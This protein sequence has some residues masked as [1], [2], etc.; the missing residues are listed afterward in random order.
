MSRV[1]AV[2]S[3]D[4]QILKSNPPQLAVSAAGQVSTSGWHSP[5]LAAWRYVTPPED[6]IQ[7]FDF[8][9]VP[10]EGIALTV[11]RPIV[12]EVVAAADP[13]N[14]WGPG[15]PL[16]GVRV[17]AQTNSMVASLISDGPLV[18]L[19]VDMDFPVRWPG[20]GGAAPEQLIGKSLRVYHTGDPITFD[21]RPSRA[22]VELGADERIVKVWVG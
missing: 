16:L 2:T 15:K 17:H 21:L 22:N 8:L 11:M 20:R 14:Y 5:E 6:A 4:V 3:V 7:D 12:A 1:F 13:L 19:S 10:P 18:P 9:A